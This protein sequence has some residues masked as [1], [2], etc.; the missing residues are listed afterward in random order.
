MGY[1][2]HV[3]ITYSVEGYIAHGWQV[4]SPVIPARSACTYNAVFVRAI[5][6]VSL[7][8]TPRACFI[9]RRSLVFI[10]P[11]YVFALSES[12]VVARSALT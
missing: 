10:R 5:Q 11:K 1:L 4:F 9:A 2:V 6:F 12:F 8:Q 3:F 7:Y